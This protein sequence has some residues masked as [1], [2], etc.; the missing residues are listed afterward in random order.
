MIT[1]DEL[2]TFWEEKEPD[3]RDWFEQLCAVQS[4][5][6]PFIG[7]GV[8]KNINGTAYPLWK[9][10]LEEIAKR[11]LLSEEAE[12]LER[13]IKAN[14]YEQAASFLQK[15]LGDVLFRDNVKRIFGADRLSGV[16]FPETVRLLTQL[17]HGNIFTTNIDR[18]I[19]TAFEQLKQ[20]K[21]QTLVPK[22]QIDQANQSIDENT[23]CLIKLHGD[24]N[25]FT[26]WVLT[27]E[28]YDSVYGKNPEDTTPF[29]SILERLMISRKLLFIG[30]GLVQDRTYDVLSRII[31]KNNTY[32]HFAFTECPKN[33]DEQ[34]YKKR[35]LINSWNIYPIW[36]P[37]A[38]YESI[39][40]LLQHMLLFQTIHTFDS[41]LK[42]K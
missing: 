29:V 27:E 32:K 21:I 33:H 4:E 18:V 24:V 5:I 40:V 19:E 1:Y 9:E 26:S 10:F 37:E 7:A 16:K 41:D 35:Q 2:M 31:Q 25:E 22:M 17:F 34:I 36:F 14:C 12:K 38:R 23:S 3:C 42:K 6:V 39:G 8:S 13:L 20:R 30:C 15:S 11:E 28:Q